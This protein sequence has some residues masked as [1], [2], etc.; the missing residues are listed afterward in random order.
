MTA[1]LKALGPCAPLSSGGFSQMALQNLFLV[2]SRENDH[3]NQMTKI[4]LVEF[5]AQRRMVW[6]MV[7]E[8]VAEEWERAF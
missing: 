8:H 3:G 5:S 1:V 2:K 7:L 4:H 6:C